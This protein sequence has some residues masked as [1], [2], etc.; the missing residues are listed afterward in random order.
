MSRLNILPSFRK[1]TT[2]S[3]LASLAN[4]SRT[5]N[6]TLQPPEAHKTAR[7]DDGA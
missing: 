2:K 1:K 5:R 3:K 6:F 4:L 7:V